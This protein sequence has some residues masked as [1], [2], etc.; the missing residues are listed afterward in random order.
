M[1]AGSDYAGGLGA[2]TG[3]DG[4]ED[5]GRESRRCLPFGRKRHEIGDQALMTSGS[6]GVKEQA[7][8]YFPRQT[9]VGPRERK[10]GQLWGTG[11][12]G[13]PLTFVVNQQNCGKFSQT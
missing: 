13:Q 9:R 8:L 7:F 10:R 1:A 3:C 2:G 6:L 4:K 5:F 12:T 11:S